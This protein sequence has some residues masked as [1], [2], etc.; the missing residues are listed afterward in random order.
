MLGTPNDPICKAIDKFNAYT[1]TLNKK[2]T[3]LFNKVTDVVKYA[4][5]AFEGLEICVDAIE[6]NWKDIL[7]ELLPLPVV[8]RAATKSTEARAV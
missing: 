6:G 1:D 3:K 2:Y 5:K 7:N 8:S 4:D